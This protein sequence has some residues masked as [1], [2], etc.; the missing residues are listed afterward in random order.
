MDL[1]RLMQANPSVFRK[2]PSFVK[3]YMWQLL[4]GLHYLHHRRYVVCDAGSLLQEENLMNLMSLVGR[5]KHGLL[6]QLDKHQG[7]AAGGSLMRAVS[8]AHPAC[9]RVNKPQQVVR[10]W[11][12][13]LISLARTSA[14]A[15]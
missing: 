10:V 11:C 9:T 8:W 7:R 5:H 3:Y 12:S 14:G 2:E 4:S 15:T 13:E 1:Y 6:Q